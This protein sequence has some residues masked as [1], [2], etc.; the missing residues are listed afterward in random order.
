MLDLPDFLG[1][2]D[3]CHKVV[4]VMMCWN[5]SWKCYWGQGDYLVGVQVA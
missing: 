4:L 3:L 5:W 1:L 2:L